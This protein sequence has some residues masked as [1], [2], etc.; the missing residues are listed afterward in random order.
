MRVI[1]VIITI[2]RS[3]QVIRKWFA[4]LYHQAAGHGP[5]GYCRVCGCR[6]YTTFTIHWDEVKH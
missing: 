5:V 2:S 1:D 3:Q 6:I 4:R